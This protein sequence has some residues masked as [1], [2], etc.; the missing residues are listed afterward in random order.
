MREKNFSTP[1]EDLG[2]HSFDDFVLSV[3]DFIP[4]C[5]KCYTSLED[6]SCGLL[7]VMSKILQVTL[8][9]FK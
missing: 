7:K 2:V 1:V 5:Q 4:R 9:S 8:Q 6:F 3:T